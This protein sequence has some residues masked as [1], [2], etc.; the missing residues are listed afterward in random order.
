MVDPRPDPL[1]TPINKQLPLNLAQAPSY[2]LSDYIVTEA[3]QDA[4]RY[5]TRIG[6]DPDSWPSHFCALVGPVSSGKTHL[7]QGWAK[8]TGAQVLEP[9]FE[10]TSIRPGHL[11]YIEDIESSEVDGEMLYSDEQLFHLFNWSKEVGAF[12]LVTAQF[13]PSQWSRTLPDLKSRLALAPVFLLN[14]PDDDLM[15]FVMAKLFSDKQ[16]DVNSKVMDYLL[17]RLERSLDQLV[18]VVNQLDGAALASK[19]RITVPLVRGVLAE[20]ETQAE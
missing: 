8:E 17:P 12:V 1:Q 20:R 10:I 4:Y 2:S 6:V 11:H 13:P 18:D 5:L 7:V 16:L 19:K 14:R 3:N 15:R 9:D